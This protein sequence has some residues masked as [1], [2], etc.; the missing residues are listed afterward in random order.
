[1]APMRYGAYVAK[2]GFAPSSDNLK[3]L[4]GES[5]DLEADYNA[6]EEAIKKFF[7]TETGVWDVKVQLALEEPGSRGQGPRVSH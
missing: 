7:R 5:I 6:L 1:M 3:E 2:V 4:T